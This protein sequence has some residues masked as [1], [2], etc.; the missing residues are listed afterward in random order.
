MHFPSAT[1]LCAA[2]LCAG[3]AHAIQDCELNGESI[4]PNNGSSTAGKTGIMRCKDRD[5]GQLMREEELQNGRSM[6]LDRFYQNGKLV[7]ERHVNERGN[8]HGLVREFAP[9]GTVLR[10]ST[11]DNGS[12]VGLVRRNH[13]NGALARATYYPAGGQG[14]QAYAELTP[15]GQLRALRCGDKPLLAPLVDDAKL[16]GFVGGPASVEMFNDTGVL[17]MRARYANGQRQRLE[18]LYPSGKPERVEETKDGQRSERRFAEDGVLRREILWQLDG[19]TASK[20]L[21]REFSERGSLVRE[22]KW[23]E[24]RA[25][26]DASFYLNGQ[27]KSRMLYSRDGNTDY[28]DE[29]AFYDSGKPSSTGRYAQTDRYNRTPVGTHQSFNAQGKLVGESIYDNRGRISRERDWD[30]DGKLLHDDEVFEDG[31]RKAYA[32]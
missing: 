31:S 2:L 9:D 18:D 5:S 25:V 14:E 23:A 6:G 26:S 28:V 16:C 17:Q 30:D 11:Y 32:K 27:P 29:T 21:E 8:N 12:E 10:E 13:P 3:A 24:R 4:N 22:Q 1:A 7:R 19:K 20:T 15:R